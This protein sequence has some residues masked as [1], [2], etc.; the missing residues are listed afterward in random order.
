VRGR[1][2]Y[3]I[4]VGACS[5]YNYNPP[6][7]EEVEDSKEATPTTNLFNLATKKTFTST[8]PASMP[9]TSRLSAPAKTHKQASQPRKPPHAEQL[10]HFGWH[11]FALLQKSLPDPQKLLPLQHNP[12][13]HFAFT[14]GPQVSP[15]CAGL[16]GAVGMGGGERLV[17]QS[18][19]PG[20]QPAAGPQ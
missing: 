3:T 9:Q 20:W 2:I 13:A 10:P 6:P 15:I 14:I 12:L 18:P 19:K 8:Q 11:Q 1:N 5:G 7:P 17:A 16:A 4:E